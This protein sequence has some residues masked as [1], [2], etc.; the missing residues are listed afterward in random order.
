MALKTVIDSLDEVDAA[1]RSHYMADGEK[2]VLAT[3]GE[4]PK[5]SEF[6]DKNIALMKERDTLKTTLEQMGEPGVAANALRELNQLKP[7]VAQLEADLLQERTTR[8]TLETRATT[9]RVRDQLRGTA[10][11]AGAWPA[12]VDLLLDK[13]DA[14]FT[15]DGDVVKAKPHIFSPTRPGEPLTPEEWV[16]NATKEFSFLFQPSVG[17][18]ATPTG[19]PPTPGS[20]GHARELRDPT[21]QQ[22]GEFATEIAT[23]KVKVVY[24]NS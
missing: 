18:G 13:A 11:K 14:V 12:A 24:T 10:L 1:L 16:A 3:Q 15:L 4:H 19:R 23:G 21:S 2:F 7:Q 20:T 5:V 8:T 9:A 17:G 22:L 6:R